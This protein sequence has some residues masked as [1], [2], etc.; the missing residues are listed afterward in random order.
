MPQETTD[1]PPVPHEM[2]TA[3]WLFN[4]FL[5]IAGGQALAIGLA[6]VVAT[7][8]AAVAAGMHSPGLL[9]FNPGPGLP[10]CSVEAWK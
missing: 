10:P 6:G 5:R 3:R 8:L 2:T 4:P 9:D 1:S 7:G